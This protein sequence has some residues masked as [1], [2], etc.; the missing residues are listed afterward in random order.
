MHRAEKSLSVLNEENRRSTLIRRPRSI[1]IQDSFASTHNF[2]DTVS[3][4]LKAPETTT[5][6]T[7][8][9]TPPQAVFTTN[10]K[11][12]YKSQSHAYWA[13]R[14][15]ALHDQYHTQSFNSAV[16]D[17]KLLQSFMRPDRPTS[18]SKLSTKLLKTR[19]S[20][21]SFDFQNF[22]H[23]SDP[24]G[25]NQAMHNDEI[26]RCKRVFYTLQ[27]L[28]VTP[29]AKNSLRGFQLRFARE[30]KMEAVLPD[31]GTMELEKRKPWNRLSM[32]R[33]S[34]VDCLGETF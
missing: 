11:C 29:E 25:G 16:N 22:A 15:M 7:A 24:P 3:S 26:R 34:T 30:K 1:T 20:T 17:E 31:G 28:C 21:S 23:C 18:T 32:R 10:P 13:G 4:L 6:S 12:I 14:F 5:A 9:A 33:S 19:L 8:P 2:T 27:S